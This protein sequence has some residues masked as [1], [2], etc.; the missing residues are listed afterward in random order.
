MQLLQA[1]PGEVLGK[2][3][4]GTVESTSGSNEEDAAVQVRFYTQAGAKLL[5]LPVEILEPVISQGIQQRTAVLWGLGLAAEKLIE[6]SLHSVFDQGFVMRGGLNLAQ[7]LYDASDRW[8][9]WGERFRDPAGAHA[10][11]DG[12][13]WDGGVIALSGPQRF[14]LEFRLR[15]R[16]EPCLLLHEREGAYA[17]QACEARPA[18]MLMQVLA[19]LC[20]AADAQFCAFPVADAWL[21][22]EDWGSLLRAPYYPDFFLLPHAAV[23]KDYPESFR[24]SMLTVPNRVVLTCLP[25]VLSNADSSTRNERELK[26]DALRKC[27]ALG[28]KYYDQLYETRFGTAGVY[29]S[30]K[31][32]F[33]DAI[34]LAEELRLKE[35]AGK[36]RH[37]LEHIKGVFRSQFS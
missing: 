31:D 16:G 2:G 9:K 23:A 10:V 6:A 28:E 34:A 18:M 8:W 1:L 13:L 30:I 27:H 37:R 20:I 26:L 29:S 15:G 35:E 3:A 25:E 11:V 32:A 36:L 19:N 22:D 24:V 17:E 21:M 33:I 7:L 12:P 4:E 5:S 14:Q